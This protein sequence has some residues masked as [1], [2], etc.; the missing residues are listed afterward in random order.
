MR[1]VKPGDLLI[2][3]T[4]YNAE[5]IGIVVEHHD[6]VSKVAEDAW[7]YQH[8][9][10]PGVTIYWQPSNIMALWLYSRLA[11]EIIEGRLRQVE[12]NES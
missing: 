11:E 4:G 3:D 9:E 12:T 2:F 5:L 7:E 6:D 10:G 1:P 8:L